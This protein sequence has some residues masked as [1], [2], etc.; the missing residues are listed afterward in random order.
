MTPTKT[1]LRDIDVIAPNL[2]W[3]FSGIT[4]TIRALVP[5]QSGMCRIAVIGPDMPASVPTIG[6]FEL[7]RFGWSRPPNRPFRIW[8]ARRNT[9]MIVG[10]IL[11]SV[12][13]QR[14]KLVF[15]SAAQRRHTGFTRWLL[16]RMDA[17][18]AI[19]PQA[20]SYLDRKSVVISHGVDTDR[21]HPAADRAAAW[22]NTG[23]PG[24]F[25]IGVFG[26]VRHQ[27]GTDLFVEAMLRLLP[28]Y[29]DFSAAIL[30]LVTPK[31]QAFVDALKARIKEAGL[32]DRIA[33]LG[34]Q[35]AD[36]L[37]LWF[38]RLSIYVAPQ[39][40]E[41]FGLTPLE[42]MASATPVVAACAGAAP[43]LVLDGETGYLVDIDEIDAMTDR[44]ERLMAD[45][46]LRAEMSIAA[47]AH[48]E[49]NHA[50]AIEARRIVDI[51]EALWQGRDPAI[52]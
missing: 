34:E 10:L 22:A 9:E 42:A 50:I 23:L 19:T 5:V 41:G 6:F 44:I 52:S 21:F 8:H 17:I 43:D 3:R 27:K 38:R 12:L 25:G 13:R 7:M 39:R 33:F 45:A 37:P 18:I 46:D 48:V 16:A 40:W 26:R 1:S 2:H 49:A 29:P 15:S 4:A 31:N 35:P 32:E 30:G 36:D 24:R 51:Y 28:R 14:L 47:R 20:A 11:R